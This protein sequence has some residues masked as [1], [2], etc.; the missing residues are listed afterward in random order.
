MT[1][2]I[3]PFENDPARDAMLS[4]LSQWAELQ[5]FVPIN[6]QQKNVL[7]WFIG[8]L[9]WLATYCAFIEAPATWALDGEEIHQETLE[10][11]IDT[12]NG[13]LRYS[14]ERYEAWLPNK[15]LSAII[16]TAHAGIM[17]LLAEE[18]DVIS[19]L[20]AAWNERQ[21]WCA[22]RPG[23]WSERLLEEDRRVKRF[24]GIV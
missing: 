7:L 21:K 11:L 13:V 3:D 17:A 9:Q 18:T 4:R 5:S 22:D 23:R 14:A 1:S 12:I 10:G 8:D 24:L 19:K 2:N 16:E 20:P 6:E 15:N